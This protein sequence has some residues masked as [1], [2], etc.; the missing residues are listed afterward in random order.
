M[1]IREDI[2]EHLRGER[3]NW[4]SRGMLVIE[5]QRL[6]R[7]FPE[8]WAAAPPWEIEEEID[9]LISDGEIEVNPVNAREIRTANKPES[10]VTSDVQQ[11][12]L[13]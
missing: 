5:L 1:S 8:Q 3:R 2:I 9:R 13:F 10:K 12:E 6:A 11:L 4:F 7:L